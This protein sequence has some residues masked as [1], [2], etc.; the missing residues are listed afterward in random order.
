ML[1]ILKEKKML[2]IVIVVAI[3]F[4]GIYIID[5]NKDYNTI[6]ENQEILIKENSKENEESNKSEE[7]ELVVVHIA[8]AVRTPGVVR[9]PD[10]SRIEDAIE[11]AGGLTDDADIS[12]INLAHILED[13]IKIKI[14]SINDEITE[15]ENNESEYVDVGSNIQTKKN[16]V[17]INTASQSELETLDGIGPSLATRIVEYRNSNG[18]FKKIEDIKNVSG[19]GDTKY[20]KI[21]ENI[22]V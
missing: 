6:E 17:N 14:P 3:I 1:E 5:L 20:E 12:N 11:A 15:E 10:G 13:G 18:K 9:L 22:K 7:Q 8:G 21:K 4:G 16:L 19:I 2:V